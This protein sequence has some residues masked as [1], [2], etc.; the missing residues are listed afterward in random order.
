MQGVISNIVTTRKNEKLCQI[1]RIPGTT[2]VAF[3]DKVTPDIGMFPDEPVVQCDVQ[4]VEIF[5]IDDS[6]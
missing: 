3:S 4:F 2:L 6:K 1:T 5:F